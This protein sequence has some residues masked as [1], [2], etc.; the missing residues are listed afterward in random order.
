M[1]S[2]NDILAIPCKLSSNA[3]DDKGYC[4]VTINGKKVLQH[5]VAYC[6]AHG[7][8]LPDIQ[9]LSI[10]QMCGNHRCMNPKHLTAVPK[11]SM[12]YKLLA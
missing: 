7:L 12:N 8:K 4:K 5:R 9:H 2:R 1:T 3:K 11:P 10:V 6:A